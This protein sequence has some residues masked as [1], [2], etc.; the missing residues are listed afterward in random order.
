MLISSLNTNGDTFQSTPSVGRATSIRRHFP[1]C[2]RFQSTPSVGRATSPSFDTPYSQFDFNP[3]PPWGGRLWLATLSASC[4]LHFNPRPPWGGRRN[5]RKT[6]PPIGSFQ[7]TPSVGRATI[8]I[9]ASAAR[10]LAFQST[11]SVGR[12]TKSLERTSFTGSISIH[13]LRGE[14]DCAHPLCCP[15]GSNFNPRPPWGGRPPTARADNEGRRIS[16]HALRG[17]GDESISPSPTR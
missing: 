2:S 15:C 1:L 16:I 8:S 12:A 14:G 6:P 5:T 7:S 9:T 11:P 3:R 13:A 17:E 4:F 10:S